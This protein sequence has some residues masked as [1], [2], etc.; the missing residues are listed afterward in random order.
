M[1]NEY[2]CI[3]MGAAGRDFHIFLAFLRD[4]PEFRVKAFTATQIPFIDQR[5]FPESLAGEGYDAD[6]PIYDESELTGLIERLEVDFVFFAY[7]D[8]SHAEIMHKACL[9]QSAGA[10]FVMLGPDHTQ[11]VSSRPVVSITATRTGAGKSPLTQW[12]ARLL[13]DQGNSV[14]VIRHPMPYG[15]LEM[16][17]VQRFATTED[18]VRHDCTIEEREEY[19][20]YVDM[21]IPIYAGVDYQAILDESSGEADIVL[22]DGG[23]NDFSFIKPDLDIVVVDSL[24]AGHEIDYF[25]GEVNFRRADILV[26]SKAGSAEP[27]AIDGI[28]KRAQQLNPE[29]VICTA[30]LELDVD[31]PDLLKGQ[32]VLVIE[33]GPTVTH[34]GMSFGAG[35][36]A[37][38]RH[39]ATPV[40]P[41]PYTVG[42]ISDT[43]EAYPHME[44]I[45]PAMGYSETQ[46]EALAETINACCAAED[47]ACIVDASPARLELMLELD[48]PMVRVSYRF[49]QIDGPPLEEQV[50]ALL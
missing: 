38:R 33:D 27:G 15:N 20:P 8:I 40:D 12:L 28:R 13:T 14:A 42:T 36:V 32:R 46:R 29:A 30:D 39:G 4:H 44:R 24:R 21:G 3:V 26:I 48:V 19:E 25:P 31:Q 1:K 5:G 23:N 6:I 41:R 37:A 35:T 18:L 50:R 7:S 43:F 10:S 45:L 16:Q 17:R 9:V 22:W 49:R 11:L 47:V 2:Q 34:G